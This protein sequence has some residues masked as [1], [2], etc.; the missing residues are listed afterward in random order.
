MRF[1][2]VSLAIA[3][4][5]ALT[6]WFFPWWMVV[7]CA[8]VIALCLP[9]TPG[10][11]FGSGFTGVGLLWLIWGLVASANND[12]ILTGRMAQLFHLPGGYLYLLV[13]A[14]AGGLVAGMAAWSAG[15]L[16]R[17]RP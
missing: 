1:W 6:T 13:S 3:L 2:L 12:F 16:S 17:R 9:Q 15:L 8:F 10:R 11:S 5:A 4:A 14:L 7:V